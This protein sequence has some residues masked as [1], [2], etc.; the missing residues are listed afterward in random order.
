M[1]YKDLTTRIESCCKAIRRAIKKE[2]NEGSEI[3]S[4]FDKNRMRI[5]N[6]YCRKYNVCPDRI[7]MI[8]TCKIATTT[9]KNKVNNAA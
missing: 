1:S 2:Y 6:K 9:K 5:I 7:Y 8:L 4:K 3:L